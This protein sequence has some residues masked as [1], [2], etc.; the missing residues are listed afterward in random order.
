MSGNAVS[1]GAGAISLCLLGGLIYRHIQGNERESELSGQVESAERR[2]GESSLELD[3]QRQTNEVLRTRLGEYQQEIQGFEQEVATLSNQV[4]QVSQS[5]EASERELEAARDA[6]GGREE[7]IQELALKGEED[8]V[9]LA[10]LARS[11]G[12]L[13]ER[14]GSL[15]HDLEQSEGERDFLLEQLAR[16]QDE[17]RQMEAVLDDLDYLKERVFQ[18]R[19]RMRAGGSSGAASA[20]RRKGAELLARGFPRAAP[21]PSEPSLDVEIRQDGEARIA[22]PPP[23]PD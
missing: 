2:L 10:R 9:Q 3:G 11:V 7:R 14:V 18:L 20:T 16:A 4:R 19:Y 17:K 6:A 23:P 5:R 15:E 1:V 12:E 22:D 13:Q 21:P 8:A